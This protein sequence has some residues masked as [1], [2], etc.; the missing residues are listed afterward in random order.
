MGGVR[1]LQVVGCYVGFGWNTGEDC[2]SWSHI[3]GSWYLP[4]LQLRGV[5]Y[6]DKH[7][8][9]YSP[10]LIVDFFMHD[11]EVSRVQRMSCCGAVEVYRG[12]GLKVFLD[13]LP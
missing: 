9:L 12:G 13:P 4:M 7:G 5:L 2:R 10:G 6:I 8:F 11:V 1:L 3:C